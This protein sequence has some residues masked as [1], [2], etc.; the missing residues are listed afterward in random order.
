MSRLSLAGCGLRGNHV[1]DYFPSAK[2]HD[3]SGKGHGRLI[4]EISVANS[5]LLLLENCAILLKYTVD[6]LGEG[7]GQLISR[8]KIPYRPIKIVT[9]GLGLRR[10]GMQHD[11]REPPVSIVVR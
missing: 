6:V 10:N 7:V 5:R 2:L 1:P 9:R 11:H 4:E 8:R 3:V